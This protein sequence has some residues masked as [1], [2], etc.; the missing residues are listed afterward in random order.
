MTAPF[1]ARAFQ[2]AHYSSVLKNVLHVLEVLHCPVDD[3]TFQFIWFNVV[4]AMFDGDKIVI[5]VSFEEMLKELREV[6][7]HWNVVF[8]FRHFE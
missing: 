8:A 1:K 5:S 2:A 4:V 6:P 7:N 3:F